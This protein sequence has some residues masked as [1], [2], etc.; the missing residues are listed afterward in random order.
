MGSLQILAG[1]TMKIIIDDLHEWLTDNKDCI[2]Y[3]TIS[4]IIEKNIVAESGYFGKDTGKEFPLYHRFIYDETDR[5]YSFYGNVENAI[6]FAA[7]YDC[8]DGQ[9]FEF[10]NGILAA[11]VRVEDTWEAELIE[12]LDSAHNIEYCGL[13]HYVIDHRGNQRTSWYFGPTTKKIRGGL[14]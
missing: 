5:E 13:V 14:E 8:W 3:V 9:E 12:D 10:E 6:E 2:D 1:E 11:E 7:R 4:W